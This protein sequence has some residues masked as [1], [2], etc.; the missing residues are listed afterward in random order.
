MYER[1]RGKACIINMFVALT[2]RF[3]PG[4]SNGPIDW[5]NPPLESIEDR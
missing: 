2:Q 3:T 1:G 5:Q 4:R